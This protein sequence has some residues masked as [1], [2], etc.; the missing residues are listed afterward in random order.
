MCPPWPLKSWFERWRPIVGENLS[1]ITPGPVPIPLPGICPNISASPPSGSLSIFILGGMNG[2]SRKKSFLPWAIGA[3]INTPRSFTA[4]WRIWLIVF[5]PL[6]RKALRGT[7]WCSRNSTVSCSR[8]R[9]LAG[10]SL[11]N[12]K[13]HILA[14]YWSIKDLARSW[15]NRGPTV[16]IIWQRHSKSSPISLSWTLFFFSK[17]VLMHLWR[18]DSWIR[19][20]LPSSPMNLMFPNIL[21]LAMALCSS[22]SGRRG[23]SRLS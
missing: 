9:I 11:L 17:S 3:G 8:K 4:S 16:L 19:S 10:N 15:S 22:S 2:P 13:E 18:I 7:Q 20:S 12:I 5:G 1:W 6:S 21:I 23:F 14:K